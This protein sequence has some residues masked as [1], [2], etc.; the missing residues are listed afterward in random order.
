MYPLLLENKFK[1][2]YIGFLFS[3]YPIRQERKYPIIM[4]KILMP[5]CAFTS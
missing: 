5:K 3:T 4:D 2:E 1:S